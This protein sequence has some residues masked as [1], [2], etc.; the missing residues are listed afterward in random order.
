MEVEI[1]PIM[2]VP[3]YSN[4]KTFEEISWLQKRVDMGEVERIDAM[5]WRDKIPKRRRNDNKRFQF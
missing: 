2:G 1:D 5:Y 4:P 3:R